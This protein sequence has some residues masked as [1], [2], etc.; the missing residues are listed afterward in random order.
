M[1]E[2]E[3]RWTNIALA[4]YS[5][6]KVP[7]PPQFREEAQRQRASMDEKLAAERAREVSIA[8]KRKR[9]PTPEVVRAER[10]R[11]AIQKEREQRGARSKNPVVQALLEQQQKREA[12]QDIFALPAPEKGNIFHK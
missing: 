10:R 9:G 4:A 6:A 1:R 5:I 8:A 12:D 3:G 7:V 2:R 11:Q